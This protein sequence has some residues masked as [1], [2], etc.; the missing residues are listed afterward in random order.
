MLS[1]ECSNPHQFRIHQSVSIQHSAFAQHSAISIH[2]AF[3]I[4]PSTFSEF[5]RLPLSHTPSGLSFAVRV[6]PRAGRSAIAGIR[7]NALAVRVAAAPVD[8]AAN[9]ALIEF[10]A[11]VF[12][13]PRRDVTINSGHASRQKRVTISGLTQSEFETRLNAILSA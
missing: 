3:T 11:D 8:D 4:Q 10:L 9:Q 7:D 12:G 5:L 6:S 2:S 1:V 13:R